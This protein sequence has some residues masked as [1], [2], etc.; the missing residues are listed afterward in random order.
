MVT[1][2]I[3]KTYWQK[4]KQSLN[5]YPTKSGR[6]FSRKLKQDCIFVICSYNSGG[7]SRDYGR[8]ANEAGL[9]PDGKR[10]STRKVP[11]N[12][13]LWLISVFG[14]LMS[15]IPLSYK[16]LFNTKIYGC[17]DGACKWEHIPL[18]QTYLNRLAGCGPLHG[19]RH[20]SGT[21]WRPQTT[22][23]LFQHRPAITHSDYATWFHIYQNGP[24]CRIMQQG[25]RK[26][27]QK[28]QKSTAIRKLEFNRIVDPL[29]L[30][31]IF[32]L[33]RS[34]LFRRSP[35]GDLSYFENILIK[36]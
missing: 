17:M 14:P 25:L 9:N 1:L 36:Q 29:H 13:F 23:Y 6:S 20:R 10:T 12:L 24:E 33:L 15:P 35:H 19:H 11:R 26:N 5:T 32:S 27:T 21:A 3:L 22:P 8:A 18:V 28:T 31:S 2:A 34:S 7:D 30:Y 16:M 4:C